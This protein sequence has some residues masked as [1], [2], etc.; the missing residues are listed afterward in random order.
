[1]L[2]YDYQKT[3]RFKATVYDIDEF[4]NEDNLNPKKWIGDVV[5]EFKDVVYSPNKVIQRPIQN[6]KRKKS[7]ICIIRGKDFDIGEKTLN[8]TLGIRNF[9]TKYDVFLRVSCLVDQVEWIPIYGTESLRCIQKQ[10]SKFK[11][12]SLHLSQFGNDENAYIKFEVLEL[13]RKGYICV[14][15]VQTLI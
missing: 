9:M 3:Q 6:P 10:L 15:E 7:G 14:G 1:M 12:F 8:L 13:S 2:P 4:S 5:F 11:P